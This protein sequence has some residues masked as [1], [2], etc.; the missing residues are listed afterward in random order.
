MLQLLN[1]DLFEILLIVDTHLSLITF[2]LGLKRRIVWDY[3]A[4]LADIFKNKIS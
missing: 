3:Q 2:S 1:K 4:P